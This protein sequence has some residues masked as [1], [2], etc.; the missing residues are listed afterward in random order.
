MEVLDYGDRGLPLA[1][2]AGGAEMS[3]RKRTI[4]SPSS[5]GKIAPSRIRT[6]VRSVHVVPEKEGGW[7]VQQ[8]GMEKVQAHFQT[9]QE[10]VEY[11]RHVSREKGAAE[12]FIHT[13]NGK[14][15]EVRT[16]S[17]ARGA[18]RGSAVK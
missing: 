7:M 4:L 18:G 12:M 10:A 9:K 3:E 15:Q 11:G 6:V 14:V 2:E 16:Y 13:K 1:P 8:G 5:T 17:A